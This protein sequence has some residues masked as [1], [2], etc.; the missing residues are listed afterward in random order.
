M[1]ITLTLARN[2]DPLAGACPDEALR[3]ATEIEL[4]AP[5][6]DRAL[7]DGSRTDP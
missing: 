5:V 3:A 7:L 2:D 1:S 4:Q 6:A